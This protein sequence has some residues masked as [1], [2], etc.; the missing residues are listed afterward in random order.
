MTRTSRLLLLALIASFASELPSQGWIRGSYLTRS[1]A[2][3]PPFVFLTQ[4]MGTSGFG[5]DVTQQFSLGDAGRQLMFMDKTL[6]QPVLLFPRQSHKNR[7]LISSQNIA[8]GSV[9]EPHVYHEPVHNQY[10]VF[11]SYAND[12]TLPH[13]SR[14]CDIYAIRLTDAV[15]RPRNFNPDSLALFKITRSP[16]TESGVLSRAFNPNWAGKAWWTG[17]L[18]ANPAIQQGACVVDEEHGPVLYYASNERR[19]GGFGLRVGDLLFT[20]SAVSLNGS[21]EIQHFGTTSLIGFFESPAGCAGA[22]QSSIESPGQ[23]GTFEFGSD[24]ALWTTL[25][26]YANGPNIADHRGT[27]IAASENPEKSVVV[28]TRYYINNN[29]GFGS[30]M[31][32]PYDK[33][34]LNTDNGGT[35][36]RQAGI[37]NLFPG[38]DP[39]SDGPSYIGKFNSPAVGRVGL[40]GGRSLRDVE[41]FATYSPNCSH[42]RI[43]VCSDPY[44]LTLVAMTDVSKSIQSKPGYNQQNPS[45]FLDPAFDESVGVHGVLKHPDFH[46][47]DMKPILTHAERFRWQH[48][49]VRPLTGRADFAWPNYPNLVKMPVAQV[50]TGPIHRTDVRPYRRRISSYDPTTVTRNGSVNRIEVLAACLTKDVIP[51][52]LTKDDVAGVRVYVADPKVQRH[53][54]TSQIRRVHSGSG[55]GYLHHNGDNRPGDDSDAMEFE[56]VRLL[57]DVPTAADGS[58]N[59]LAPANATLRFSLLHRDGTVLAAQRNHHSFRPGQV[60]K[61]CAGCHDHREQSQP[62][63]PE[64]GAAGVPFDTLNQTGKFAWDANGSLKFSTSPV[65]TL[66]VPEF[67]SDIWPIMKAECASCHDSSVNAGGTGLARFNMNMPFSQSVPRATAEVDRVT[68]IWSWLHNQRYINRI[69]GSAKSP[70]TWYFTGVANDNAIRLDGE[71][72]N[73]YRGQPGSKYWITTRYNGWNPHPGI[74]DRSAAYK[75]IEWID[76]GA[77]IDHDDKEPSGRIING[78]GLNYD[79]YQIALST[80]IEHGPFNT[81]DLVV[82]Y[83]DVVANV[84]SIEVKVNGERLYQQTVPL[85]SNGVVRTPLPYVLQDRSV[86]EVI[87]KDRNGNQSRVQKTLL[88]MLLESEPL[89]GD[90]R[91]GVGSPDVTHARVAP[92]SSTDLFVTAQQ[93]H[94]GEPFMLAGGFSG[95]FPGGRL[96]GLEGVLGLAD[97][98]TPD[99]FLTLTLSAGV[100]GVLDA[101]GSGRIKLVV[102]AALAGSVAELNWQVLAFSSVALG[103]SNFVTLQFGS[104]GS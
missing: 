70:F 95:Y 79:G 86:I 13:V 67:K 37:W 104:G 97:T 47:F 82:G 65:P 100:V 76:A 75:V 38:I 90:Y 18:S 66:P 94:A 52:S 1:G 74:Q 12:L 69:I 46:A 103:E 45:G 68:A 15:L 17:G 54:Y 61:R 8:D 64:F 32:L 49:V 83:W 63:P 28:V 30:L 81:K 72:N 53:Y 24:E 26:G 31:M 29:E 43:Q 10:W 5:M 56:R 71:T 87:A 102:P 98:L 99:P 39:S 11:F 3:C 42:S 40:A 73:R 22:Y 33:R 84:S 50:L 9:H 55:W 27:T 101:T 88:Q 60:E 2:D 96:K 35:G 85:G 6:Q 93:W 62:S 58:V 51:E 59:F 48:R 44:H 14:P 4:P 21:R 25:S 57:S 91:L 78:G 7:G 92:G 41:L 20:Q 89:R 34:G 19:A 23:W 16:T 36:I 80:L 77:G